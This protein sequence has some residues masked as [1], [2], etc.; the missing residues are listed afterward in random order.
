SERVIAE[1]LLAR[2][3]DPAAQRR[4]HGERLLA[5]R[6]QPAFLVGEA[7]VV[8]AV[9][10]VVDLV[11]YVRVRRGEV[12]QS[13][14][15]R[16]CRDGED[17]REGGPRAT[18]AASEALGA[19]RPDGRDDRRCILRPPEFVRGELTGLARGRRKGTRRSGDP[20]RL[21]GR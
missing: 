17:D 8:T 9:L 5:G 15:G 21:F 14:S 2:G 10:R 11:E 13:K 7:G 3:D 1:C 4:V 19:G 12:P 6:V 18:A 20:R 16:E